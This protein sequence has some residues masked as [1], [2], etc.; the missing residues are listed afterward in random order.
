MG[1]DEVAGGLHMEVLSE[2]IKGLLDHRLE[3]LRIQ[4][5]QVILSVKEQ[6][7]T[8]LRGKL[9]LDTERQ[10]RRDVSETLEVFL[11]PKGDLSKLRQQLRGISL[12]GS[13]DAVYVNRYSEDGS[14]DNGGNGQNESN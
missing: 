8:S 9:L 7:P 12:D 13:K 4:G 5:K 2:K 11:E 6:M 14:S 3:F 10:L 1:V